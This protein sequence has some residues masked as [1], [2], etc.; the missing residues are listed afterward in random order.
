M[1]AYP[2]KNLSQI[3]ALYILVLF[4]FTNVKATVDP[5]IARECYSCEGTTCQRTTKLNVTTT[6]YDALDTCVTIFDQFTVAAKGCYSDMPEILRK[7]CTN[8]ANPECSQCYDQLCNNKARADIKCI[9]CNSKE[10]IRCA[11]D[12]NY[13]IPKQCDAPTA[14]NTYCYV[15]KNADNIII[16]GCL[17]HA[18]DQIACMKD[19]TCSMCHA[20]NNPGCNSFSLVTSS[21]NTNKN[22]SHKLFGV[23][24]FILFGFWVK[25]CSIT[26]T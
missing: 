18:K 23:F 7:K 25:K 1:L 6:C 15:R 12:T 17:V 26:N 20:G 14:S 16:R 2:L 10:Q 19:D 8:T 5:V 4:I 13:L 21:A 22:I 11:T 24:Y 3:F 9:E